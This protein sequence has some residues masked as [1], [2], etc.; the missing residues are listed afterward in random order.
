MQFKITSFNIIK[1]P[2]VRPGDP[3]ESFHIKTKKGGEVL[4]SPPFLD[5]VL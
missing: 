3:Q 2:Y 4:P 1:K 5:H